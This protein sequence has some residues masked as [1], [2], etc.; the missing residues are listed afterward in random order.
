MLRY[1]CRCL[2]LCCAVVAN[3][4]QLTTTPMRWEKAPICHI[5]FICQ[6]KLYIIES[7]SWKESGSTVC[8]EDETCCFLVFGGGQCNFKIDAKEGMQLFLRHQKR[9]QFWE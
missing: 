1:Q 8:L 4:M 9:V 2:T 7:E 6:R 5:G 3:Q